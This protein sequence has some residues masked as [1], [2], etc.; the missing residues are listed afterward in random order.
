MLA[1]RSAHSV[2]A[3]HLWEYL[4]CVKPY[5]HLFYLI[6]SVNRRL[7]GLNLPVLAVFSERDEIVSRKSMAVIQKLACCETSL[8]D[9]CGH[10]YYSEAAKAVIIEKLKR[11]I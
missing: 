9:G 6:D 1:A 5:L 11:Y 8:A 2:K 10:L 7:E 3:T 4:L